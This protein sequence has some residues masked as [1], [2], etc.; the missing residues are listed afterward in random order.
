M[1][2]QPMNDYMKS[3]TIGG[4]VKQLRKE[5][6]MTQEDL[7]ARSGLSLA[8]IQRAERG[9]RLSA[10]TI[11][12]LAAAFDLDPTDLTNPKLDRDD[13]PYLPLKAIQSGRQLLGL[14]AAG[15][16]LNFAF[17]ELSDLK[18]AELIERLQTWCQPLGAERVPA[19]AIA[20]VKLE[21]E[22]TQ[23]LREMASAN[24]VVTGATFDVHAYDI[25][26]DGDGPS[27]VMAEW[28]YTCAVIRVG[29]DR[30]LV[31][32]AYVM[33]QL[34][35]YEMPTSGVI[36]PPTPP[37]STNDILTAFGITPGEDK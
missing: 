4:R 26:D 14:I 15:S 18:Q 30:K 17:V 24:L 19:G 3:M 29:T 32:R 33:D 31:D 10:D 5:S 7:M 1:E 28:N 35:E 13:Q 37:I 12:S 2:A 9:Q 34:G 36:F 22:A 16:V 20:Q 8:T 25:L 27:M 23:L 21:L 11:A 6:A